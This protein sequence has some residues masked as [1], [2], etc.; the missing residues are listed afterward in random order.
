[1]RLARALGLP[2][3]RE[4]DAPDFAHARWAAEAFGYPL[5]LKRDL[6]CGG[7]GVA[8]ARDAIQLK[9]GFTRL[10][11]QGRLRR[12]AAGLPGYR[13]SGSAP[14]TAQE[15]I[16]GALAHRVAACQEGR[17]LEGMDFLALKREPFDTGPSRYI[18]GV[19]QPEM[20][21]ASRRVIAALKLSGLASFDFILNRRGEAWLIEINPRPSASAHLG[22]LFGHDL[23]AALL[24]RAEDPRERPKLRAQPPETIALFPGAIDAEP[25][26]ADFCAGSPFFRDVPWNYSEALAA[27]SQWL[28]QR[29]PDVAPVLGPL[30]SPRGA[31][32]ATE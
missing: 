26:G 29:H 24:R 14:L 17:E 27:Y 18:R 13:F 16:P 20:A 7:F 11:R 21:E 19:S 5:A 1:M 25:R 28:D 32:L 3:P 30:R 4:A 9:R 15:F 31:V 6:T 23:Y 12:L 8:I 22:A 2:T 10:Q